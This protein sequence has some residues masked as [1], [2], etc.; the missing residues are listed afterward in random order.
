MLRHTAGCTAWPLSQK[1]GTCRLYSGIGQ[2]RPIRLDNIENLHPK[3]LL[4]TV[5][6][7]RLGGHLPSKP[8]GSPFGSP[9]ATAQTSLASEY[10]RSLQRPHFAASAEAEAVKDCSRTCT[11]H[12]PLDR[13][14]LALAPNRIG[15]RPRP[16]RAGT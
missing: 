14:I 4:G 13:L 5:I 15:A 1:A 11:F 7:R 8:H 10:P 12:E 16:G 2:V 9:P 3:V 6:A